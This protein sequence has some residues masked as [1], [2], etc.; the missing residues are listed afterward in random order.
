MLI[1]EKS[2]NSSNRRVSPNEHLRKRVIQTSKG[3]KA[4]QNSVLDRRKSNNSA[5]SLVGLLISLL[6]VSLTWTSISTMS[7]RFVERRA[8]GHTSKLI[9][10]AMALGQEKGLYLGVPV[11]AFSKDGSTIFQVK[12]QYFTNKIPLPIKHMKDLHVYSGVTSLNKL[13][14]VRFLPN[15]YASP[16]R[17]ELTGKYYI[18][19]IKVSLRGRINRSCNRVTHE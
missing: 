2:T 16:A 4:R 12:S 17:I 15:G 1:K 6:L 10:H 19:Q 5:Y 18:C 8:L 14:E 13:P 3:T 9:S 11:S 7:Y